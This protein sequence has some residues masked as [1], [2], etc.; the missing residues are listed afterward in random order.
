MSVRK[1]HASTEVKV[2]APKQAT[3]ETVRKVLS[4]SILTIPQARVELANITG[5]R[6]DRATL[7]RWIL[8]GVRGVRLEACRVGPSWITSVEALNRFVVRVTDKSLAS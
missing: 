6:P 8:R 4:E 5:Q 1:T 2:A 3:E 7:H